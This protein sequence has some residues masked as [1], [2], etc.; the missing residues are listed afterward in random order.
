MS[1]CSS[2]GVPSN[3]ADSLGLQALFIHVVP[4]ASNAEGHVRFTVKYH[5]SMGGK[6]KLSAST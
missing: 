4:G 3:W 2:T 5:V 1:A 6:W